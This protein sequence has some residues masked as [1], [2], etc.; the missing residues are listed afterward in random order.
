MSKIK[1]KMIEIQEDLVKKFMEDNPGI[2]IDKAYDRTSLDAYDAA[3]SY[4]RYHPEEL[5]D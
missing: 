5:N 3:L 1:N 4:F 2:P